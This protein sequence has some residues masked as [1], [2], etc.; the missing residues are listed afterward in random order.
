MIES[1]GRI[2]GSTGLVWRRPDMKCVHMGSTAAD[3]SLVE[4]KIYTVPGIVYC[5]S[6]WC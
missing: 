5:L 2:G 6:E 3:D 1:G 4:A